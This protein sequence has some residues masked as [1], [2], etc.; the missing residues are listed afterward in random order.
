[1]GRKGASFSGVLPRCHIVHRSGR[2]RQRERG[3]DEP[4]AGSGESR[5]GLCP[6]VLACE[7]GTRSAISGRTARER[8]V[9]QVTLE[10]EGFGIQESAVTRVPGC[11]SA[12]RNA[13]ARA[14]AIP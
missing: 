2:D 7:S 1:M 8:D 3:T 10:R 4:R 5:A 13:T 6:A 9:V 12:Q 14:I 11:A